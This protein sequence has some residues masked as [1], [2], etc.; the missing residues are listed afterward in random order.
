[1]DGVQEGL[2]YEDTCTHKVID[3]RIGIFITR[4]L[5]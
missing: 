5:P 4:E 2:M 3:K 1:M